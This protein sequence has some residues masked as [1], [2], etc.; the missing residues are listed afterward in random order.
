M[1]SAVPKKDAGPNVT[2]RVPTGSASLFE[3]SIATHYE[4]TIPMKLTSHGTKGWSVYLI[5]KNS[6]QGGDR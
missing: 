6:T 1:I 4:E 3:G 5:G 2:Q